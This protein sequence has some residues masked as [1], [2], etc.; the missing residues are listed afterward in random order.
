MSLLATITTKFM[1]K[2]QLLVAMPTLKFV[3]VGCCYTLWS[4]TG[5][6]EV[7]PTL[8]KRELEREE[9]GYIVIHEITRS[10]P[11]RSR[12]SRDVI[13]LKLVRVDIGLNS[14]GLRALSLVYRFG[15]YV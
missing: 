11:G 10:L 3:I 8:E 6:V 4:F 9:A 5:K 13:G 2:T 7:L 12:N 1:P 14:E 15:G